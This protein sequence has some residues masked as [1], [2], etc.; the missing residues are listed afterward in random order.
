LKVEITPSFST[1][2]IFILGTL[3]VCATVF[4]NPGIPI[5]AGIPFALSPLLLRSVRTT[6]TLRGYILRIAIFALPLLVMAGIF[7]ARFLATYNQPSF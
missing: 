4:P 2:F 1:V 5:Y 6:N 3:L 7:V